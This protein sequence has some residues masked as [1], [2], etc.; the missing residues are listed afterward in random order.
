MIDFLDNYMNHIATTPNQYHIELAQAT[1]NQRWDDTTQIY[2]IKEQKAYP[3]EDEYEEHEVWLSTISDDLTNT[4]KV[5]SDFISVLFKDID[6]KQNYKGQYYKLTLS[7]D[8]GEETYLCYD[9]INKLSVVAETK[10]VR[11]NNTL[12]WKTNS[13]KIVEFPC[14]LGTD[15]SST[16]NQISKSGIVPN[17]RMIILVQANEFTK[18]IVNNQRFMFGHSTVFKVEETNNFMTEQGTNGE[19]T[20]IKLYVS[21]SPMT[22]YD[23]KEI[24]IC[25]YFSSNYSLTIDQDDIEQE[26]GFI[27]QLNA[28]TTNDGEIVT[29]P[30]RWVSD[31]E[32][33]VTIDKDGNFEIVGN[34]GETATIKCYIEDNQDVY[35]SIQVSVVQTYPLLKMI[36][37]TP[38]NVTELFQ[39]EQ[40]S[41]KCGVYIEGIAQSDVVTC[42]PSGANE[43][44]YKITT[45]TDGFNIKNCG[46]SK[47]PLTLTFIANGCQDKVMNIKLLNLI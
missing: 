40:I 15:I 28:T 34:V 26:N 33:V 23:N 1:I 25:D 35:D 5:Y 21:Y 3:F 38:N 27:G 2:T 20:S 13:G 24:N 46:S 47:I 31:N 32:E 29:L 9:R 7:E 45:T 36:Q 11:C 37:T 39:G 16:N 44:C 42:V 43:K 41:I 30:L 19:I 6:H 10:I 22:P 14:Y 17:V 4:A 12:R 18:Q 8:E